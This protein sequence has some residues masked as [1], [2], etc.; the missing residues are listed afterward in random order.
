MGKQLLLKKNLLMKN[1]EPR[2][3]RFF[4]KYSEKIRKDNMD[5]FLTIPKRIQTCKNSV[6]YIFEY[7]DKDYKASKI[8]KL[9]WRK[10]LDYTIQVCL[11]I[12]YLN[13]NLKLFHHDLFT[14]AG[15]TKIRNMMV[16]YGNKE[17]IL[18]V[19]E[20]EHI[21]KENKIRIIDFGYIR[22][23]PHYKL[24]EYYKKKMKNT[25]FYSEVFALLYLSYR[26]YLQKWIDFPSFF[27]SFYKSGMSHQD[28]DKKL[29]RRLI[30]A[31]KHS[32]F[33][34][35]FKD[36]NESTIKVSVGDLGSEDEKLAEVKRILGK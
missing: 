30:H 11:Q 14:R 32:N 33:T 23:S 2:E 22:E 7:L 19:N 17:Q 24:E 21:V 4:K 5:K 28:F 34:N 26:S 8:P 36:F 20:F 29:I 31:Y 10:F 12:F 1:D 3:Y 35:L 15:G 16:Q 25:P 18:R 9:T 13:H 27:N 6:M